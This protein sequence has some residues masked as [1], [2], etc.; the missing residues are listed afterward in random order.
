MTKL[1]LAR[2]IIDRYPDRR[3]HVVTD[4]DCATGGLPGLPGRAAS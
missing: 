1:A 3:T 4:D 2:H